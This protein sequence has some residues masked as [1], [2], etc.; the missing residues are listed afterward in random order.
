MHRLELHFPTTLPPQ[1]HLMQPNLQLDVSLLSCG[2]LKSTR[3]LANILKSGSETTGPAAKFSS[4]KN[5]ALAAIAVILVGGATF[6]ALQPDK[7]AQWGEKLKEL[8]GVQVAK[9]DPAPP[10]PT[11]IPAPPA[12]A[13]LAPSVIKPAPPVSVAKPPLS[14]KIPEVPKITVAISRLV[15]PQGG[16]C[17][18]VHFGG[19]EPLLKL[20]PES[21]AGGHGE[22]DRGTTCGL[23]FDFE[24]A[25]KFLA[26][27]LRLNSGHFI[28]A[29]KKPAALS[30]SR[31]VSGLQTWTIQLPQK[32]KEPFSYDLAV[33]S[34]DRPLGAEFKRLQGITNFKTTAKEFKRNQIGLMVHSHRVSA[35]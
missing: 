11:P 32:A 28:R 33:L 1:M 17:M 30:G 3:L 20:V 6:A 25:G 16:T 4:V 34:S 12:A 29:S 21:A 22:S 7:F 24:G 19:A 18:Q 23:R 26:V 14:P 35:K 10:T 27:H 5:V 9:E 8:A 15:P 31:P 2:S 13:P